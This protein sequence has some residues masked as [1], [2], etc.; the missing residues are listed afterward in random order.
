MDENG[1]KKWSLTVEGEFDTSPTLGQ[2]GRVFFSVNLKKNALLYSIDPLAIT[3]TE[4]VKP[5]WQ[6]EVEGNIFSPPLVTERN[7]VFVGTVI[8]N[9]EDI[10]IDTKGHLYAIESTLGNLKW[11]FNSQGGIFASL[12]NNGNLIFAGSSIITRKDNEVRMEGTLLSFDINDINPDSVAPLFVTPLNGAML[13]SPLIIDNNL[14]LGTID[15]MFTITNN[16]K[17]RTN[18]DVPTSTFYSIDIT[19]RAIVL[20]VKLKSIICGATNCRP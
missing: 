16:D 12:V 15:E 3:D 18:F 20:E 5:E 17:I 14:Y 2:N 11:D 6:F 10:T 4:N 1:S 8:T 9:T 13:F 7:T 19:K